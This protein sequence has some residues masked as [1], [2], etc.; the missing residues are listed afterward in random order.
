MYVA[1]VFFFFFLRIVRG[2]CLTS[3]YFLE[4]E[5]LS[6]DYGH[7]VMIKLLQEHM[8]YGHTKSIIE[9]ESLPATTRLYAEQ[10]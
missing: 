7:K 8:N 10:K 4:V 6:G 5:V 9:V 1:L 2:S 3:V